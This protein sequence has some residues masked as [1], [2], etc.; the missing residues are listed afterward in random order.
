MTKEI[1]AMLLAGGKGTR[2][3][4][5]TKKIAKPAVFFGGKYRIIDFPLSNCSNSGIDTVGILTQ[6]ES[7]LLN[8]YIGNGDKWGLNGVRSLTASLPP[9]Q[10]E[11]GSNWYSGTADAIFQNL[12][13]LDNLD[14]QYVLILSGDH[15]YKMDYQ[16]MLNAHKAQKADLTIAVI[17][18]SL[19]EASRFGI[20]STHSDG[21]IYK[22]SE[23]PKKPDSTLASMGIYIFD[24]KVL[25]AALR[26]DAKDDNSEHDFGK[27][28]IPTLLSRGK[29]LLA[30]EFKGYWKDVGTIDSLW[31]ANMDTIDLLTPDDLKDIRGF[32]RI[33]TEDTNSVPQYIG[34]E[35]SVT[36][37]VVN[38]GAIILGHV[39]HSVIF[40]EVLIEEG[41][42][43]QHC[44]LLPG[45]VVKK[46]AKVVYAIVGENVVIDPG[47]EVLG[48]K[49]EIALVAK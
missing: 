34:K 37:S 27:N 15:I 22:F 25:R 28:I 21:T 11:E 5:L 31:Q 7:V 40:N 6:Y 2:L 19:E 14:P 41:A 48:E 49:D 36:E 20:M 29:K 18:V 46:G 43:V 47:T 33:Y 44:V 30:Y 26:E 42:S 9:R 32:E 45:A 17:N 24:Y 16:K 13:F 12:D 35:A 8:A 4:A 23:K 38:Q 39:H 1:V 3:Y 10:T